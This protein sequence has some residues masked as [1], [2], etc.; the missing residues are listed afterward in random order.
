MPKKRFDDYKRVNIYL[1]KPQLEV[2]NQIENYSAFVQIATDN[3]ADIM[4]WA[5]L[6]KIDP[7]KY[8]SLHKL[9]EVIDDFNKKYPKDQPWPKPSAKLPDLLS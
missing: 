7:K 2:K 8:H 5:L 4:A 1:R 9:P 3:A 6:R